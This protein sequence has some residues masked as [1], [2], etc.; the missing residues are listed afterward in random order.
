MVVLDHPDAGCLAVDHV[1][2]A[3]SEAPGLT[4][5]LLAPADPPTRERIT[6]RVRAADRRRRGGDGAPA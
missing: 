2:L 6:R 4:L 3:V 1:L 5:G